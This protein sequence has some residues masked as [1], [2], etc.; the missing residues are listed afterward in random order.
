MANPDRIRESAKRV[1]RELE[2]G[3][4][5]VVAVSAMSGET[6]KLLDLG[7]AMNPAA[8]RGYVPAKWICWPQQ[9]NRCL[10]P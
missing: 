10:S 2:R 3:N 6:D 8:G 7:K 1:A 9:A 5:V 4:Q